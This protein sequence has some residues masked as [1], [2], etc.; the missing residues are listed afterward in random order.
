MKKSIIT[1]SVVLSFILIGCPY[2][3]KYSIGD[4]SNSSIDT[5]IIG[6]W[7]SCDTTDNETFEIAIFKFNEKEYYIETV[8]IRNDL[9]GI[10]IKTERYKGFSTIINNVFLLNIQLIELESIENA[11][12]ITEVYSFFKYEIVSNNKLKLDYISDEYIKIDFNSQQELVKYVQE[13]IMQDGFFENF[14]EFKKIE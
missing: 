14:S 12:K 2:E 4:L 3:S 5:T 10:N 13:N 8:D 1:L 11:D 6:R 9:N 7:Y